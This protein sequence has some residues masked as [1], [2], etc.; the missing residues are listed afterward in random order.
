VNVNASED[1]WMLDSA[2][3]QYAIG[4]SSPPG[5]TISVHRSGAL[6]SNISTA[7]IPAFEPLGK[8]YGI[9]D[10]AWQSKQVGRPLAH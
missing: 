7:E 3:H 1:V 8:A 10:A 6:A 9:K 5:D 4:F 2:W